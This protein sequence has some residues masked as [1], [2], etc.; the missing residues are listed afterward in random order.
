MYGSGL[1]AGA[2]L[3]LENMLV[4][5]PGCELCGGASGNGADGGAS[6]DGPVWNILVN[7]PGPCGLCA[8]GVIKGCGAGVGAVWPGGGPNICVKLPSE[9]EGGG[10]AGGASGK[11]GAEKRPEGPDAPGAAK[12]PDGL[13][14]SSF[15]STAT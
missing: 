6:N 12:R 8:G 11:T 3:R 15:F 13:D 7:S 14:P 2:P 5:E 4:N 1:A 10:A 9:D